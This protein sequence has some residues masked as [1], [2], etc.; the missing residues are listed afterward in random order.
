MGKQ[1]FHLGWFAKFGPPAWQAG[2]DRNYGADWPNGRV[3]IDL[4]QRLERACFDFLLFE[5]TQTVSTTFGGSMALDLKH[6]FYSPKHDPLPLLSVL[7]AA[8]RSIGF[9]GTASTT[10]YPP[11]LLARLFATLDGLSEGR[12]GWNVVTSSEANAARNYGMED[13]PSHE[14]R[15]ARADEFIE[16]TKSLWNSWEKNALLQDEESGTYVDYTK[17]HTVNFKG[18]YYRSQGPLNTLR[19]PQGYPVIAQ[20]GAS[21]RGK[22]L[23]AKY[24]DVVVANTAGGVEG[25]KAKRDDIRARAAG[26]GRNPDDSKVFFICSPVI[27]ESE[28]EGIPE[29][30][31]EYLLAMFS[32]FM[33]IDLSVYDPD[34]PFP[35]DVTAN[36]HTSVLE[37]LKRHGAAGKTLRGAVVAH[38]MG[39]DEFEL[40]GPAESIAEK[41]MQAMDEIGGD[42]FLINGPDLTSP[43]YIEGVTKGI[44]PVLQKAG[45]TRSTYTGKT[46]K[47]VLG[48]F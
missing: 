29:P 13:L 38:G 27:T 41:M 14:E 34:G 16:L 1:Q 39:A 15:Y 22:N 28:E 25:M 32:S 31:F 8:T 30:H 45:A 47:E 20:A 11:F 6:A 48:E 46:L 33:D 9:I 5:D 18:Q 10:F 44:V 7:A 23:A 36:G 19:P 35:Q 26:A 3:Y 40:V 4:A 24:A 21:A 42:G 17:V 37:E 43:A 2:E 12:I